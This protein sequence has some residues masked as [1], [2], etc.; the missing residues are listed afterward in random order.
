V[1]PSSS[2]Q[3][4]FIIIII[5]PKVWAATLFWSKHAVQYRIMNWGT[6]TI[7]RTGLL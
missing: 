6:D 3:W 4:I 1:C 5:P 2:Y 7:L